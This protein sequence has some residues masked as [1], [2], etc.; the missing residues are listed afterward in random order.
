M[1]LINIFHTITLPV[2]YVMLQ[3]SGLHPEMTS[4]GFDSCVV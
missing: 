2:S 1:E 4:N 3:E